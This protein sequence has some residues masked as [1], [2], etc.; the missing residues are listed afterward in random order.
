MNVSQN[1]SYQQWQCISPEVTVEGSKKCCISS[2]VDGTD[3]GMLWTGSKGMAILGVGVRKM[4]AL[5]V[6]TD[7]VTPTSKGTQN[8]TCF[9]YQVYAINRTVFLFLGGGLSFV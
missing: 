1:G 2:A 9:V 7:T 6:K 5:T 4:K 8:V 3:G